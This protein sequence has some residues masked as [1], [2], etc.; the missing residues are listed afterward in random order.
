MPKD[1]MRC[2]NCGAT[3][4]E[5]NVPELTEEEEEF[6][7]GN[8]I[9]DPKPLFEED[10]LGC[11]YFDVDCGIVAYIEPRHAGNDSIYE[12]HNCRTILEFEA[13]RCPLCGGSL[14]KV[15]DGI[16]EIV[17]GIIVGDDLDLEISRDVF[18]PVCGDLLALENGRCIV[19][20]TQLLSIVCEDTDY[21]CPVVSSDCLVFVHL[22]VED[23]EFNYLMKG[24]DQECMEAGSGL[25]PAPPDDEINLDGGPG[26]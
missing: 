12:C 25:L 14:E 3:Y 16:V 20:G 24:K 11:G 6:L 22:N 15:E 8:E 5:E 21:I 10:N 23:G 19:C 26:M 13:K 1:S 17:N 7:F 9:D 18:C 4:I 2:P